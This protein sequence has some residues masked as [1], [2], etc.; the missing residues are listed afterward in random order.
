MGNLGIRDV[1]GE[2]RGSEE[3]ECCGEMMALERGKAERTEREPR[4]EGRRPGFRLGSA[5]DLLDDLRAEASETSGTFFS[6]H[7]NLLRPG[8][9]T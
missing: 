1:S 5:V 7:R 2:L 8:D 3:G 6:T 4:L 9:G